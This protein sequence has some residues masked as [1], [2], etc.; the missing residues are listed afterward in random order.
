M[1]NFCLSMLK[2][3]IE[4]E[5]HMFLCY[6]SFPK[7]HRNGSFFPLFSIFFIFIYLVYQ[8]DLVFTLQQSW[9][10]LLLTGPSNVLKCLFS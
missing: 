3:W 2:H 4:V 9:I 1:G 7:T 10:I 5:G 8:I 6:A